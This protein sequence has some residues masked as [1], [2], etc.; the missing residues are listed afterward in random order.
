MDT[1]ILLISGDVAQLRH[2]SVLVIY[3]SEEVNVYPHPTLLYE[4]PNSP[5]TY[6]ILHHFFLWSFLFQY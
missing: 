6:K 1:N 3:F 2:E 4:V 5:K